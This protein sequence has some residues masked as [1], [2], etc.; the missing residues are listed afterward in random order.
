MQSAW[1]GNVR[2]FGDAQDGGLFSGGSD[3]DSAAQALFVV[4]HTFGASGNMLCEQS[5]TEVVRTL[6][7][8]LWQA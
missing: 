6:E 8:S 5:T 4:A 3:L 1:A 2:L 7:T